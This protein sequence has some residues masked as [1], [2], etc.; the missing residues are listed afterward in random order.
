[1]DARIWRRLFV[2]CYVV[3]IQTTWR[4]HSQIRRVP[5]HRQQT[6]YAVQMVFAIEQV[7]IDQE[8]QRGLL[9]FINGTNYAERR[10]T[11]PSCSKQRRVREQIRT[12]AVEQAQGRWVGSEVHQRF[13]YVDHWLRSAR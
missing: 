12:V 6:P 13:S 2:E 4:E 9:P 1:L 5:P 8:Y 10:V 7:R 11:T 3:D